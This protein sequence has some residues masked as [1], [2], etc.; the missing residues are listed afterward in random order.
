MP[1]TTFAAWSIWEKHLYKV[2]F[3][4]CWKGPYA[5]VVTNAC[6]TK[7]RGWTPKFVVSAVDLQPNW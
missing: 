5:D 7:L 1:N 6:V 4:L 2:S 3:Q